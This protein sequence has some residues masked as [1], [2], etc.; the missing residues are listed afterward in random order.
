[1]PESCI[2]R[3]NKTSLLRYNNI[4]FTQQSVRRFFIVRNNCNFDCNMLNLL[5]IT[6]KVLCDPSHVLPGARVWI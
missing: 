4:S 3:V 1:M 5:H 2:M 6:Q